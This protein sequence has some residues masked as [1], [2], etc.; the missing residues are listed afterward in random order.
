VRRPIVML[1]ANG[2]L[3]QQLGTYLL[4]VK[5]QQTSNWSRRPLDADQL[6]YA[7]LDTEVL[8]DLYARRKH[9]EAGE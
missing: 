5:S 1:R 9:P 2:R 8:L 7:A 3:R 4:T 6:R